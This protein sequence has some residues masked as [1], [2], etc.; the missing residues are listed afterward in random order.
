MGILNDIKKALELKEK[1]KQEGN[2]SSEI[3]LSSAATHPLLRI[4]N[5]KRHEWIAEIHKI[6][7]IP[8]VRSPTASGRTKY[9][10]FKGKVKILINTEMPFC[11]GA[12]ICAAVKPRKATFYP[13]NC[14]EME[15]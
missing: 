8:L 9:M 4:K 10:G 12:K 15:E 13:M 11:K 7:D 14:F 5:V 2:F 6:L 3:M 1:L